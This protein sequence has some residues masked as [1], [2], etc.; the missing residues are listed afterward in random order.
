MSP[1]R[2]ATLLASST[3]FALYQGP[4]PMRSRALT[5][6]WPLAAVVLR[7][8]SHVRP[9]AG[10]APAAFA[11]IAQFASAPA[12]PPMFA[13]S[14][15]PTLVTKNDMGCVAAACAPP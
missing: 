5:A 15:L 1:C 10:G 4:A 3:F 7:Y 11:S 14:P 9:Y 13:P 6:G 12:R 8:A 2:S